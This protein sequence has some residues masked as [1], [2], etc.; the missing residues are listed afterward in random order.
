M[1]A[2]LPLCFDCYGNGFVCPQPSAGPLSL[3][4]EHDGYHASGKRLNSKC[5]ILGL[6]P[7]CRAVL[8]FLNFFSESGLKEGETNKI[9]TARHKTGIIVANL[10]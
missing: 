9:A 7:A 6:C 10:K 1:V 8:L 4:K 3:P 2:L 5:W